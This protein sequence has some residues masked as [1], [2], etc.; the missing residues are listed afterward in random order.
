M[1]VNQEAVFN[2]DIILFYDNIKKFLIFDWVFF[3]V[4]AKPVLKVQ[5]DTLLI[6]EGDTIFIVC[7]W[8]QNGHETKFPQIHL[9]FLTVNGK[10]S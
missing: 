3:L 2:N 1:I 10:E 7:Y 5:R 8:T 9:A 4:F 6:K